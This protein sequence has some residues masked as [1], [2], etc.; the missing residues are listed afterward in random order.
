M[1]ED[2]PRSNSVQWQK[3]QL[4]SSLDQ[5]C[6]S[7]SQI[8]GLKIFSLVKMSVERALLQ[9]SC[10]FDKVLVE[11]ETNSMDRE[12]TSAERHVILLKFFLKNF[13]EQRV[14]VTELDF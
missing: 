12:Y 13:E 3:Q 4:V 8:A 6:F 14:F 5:L 1:C 11:R 10:V 2:F 9:Q 7:Q